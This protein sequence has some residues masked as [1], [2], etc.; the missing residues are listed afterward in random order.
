MALVSNFPIF[1]LGFLFG[2]WR[3]YMTSWGIQNIHLVNPQIHVEHL[4]Q[5]STV[6]C[7]MDNEVNKTRNGPCPHRALSLVGKTD[8]K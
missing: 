2:M 8:I 5:A 4:Q 3:Q 1:S 6:L 7:I